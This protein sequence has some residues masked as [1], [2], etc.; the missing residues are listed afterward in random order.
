MDVGPLAN[1]HP[2]PGETVDLIAT[3]KNFGS[4]ATNVHIELEASDPYITIIDGSADLGDMAEGQVADNSA[5]PFSFEVAAHA[6]TG[7]I[8]QLSL[9]ATF[10]GGE[11]PSGLVVC[12]GRYDYLVWD[13][14]G[15]H[16]SGPIIAAILDGLHYS[17]AYTES[18]PVD[19]L[20]DYASLWVSCGVYPGNHVVDSGGLE[21]PAIVDYMANGGSVYL[22]GG[23]VWAY[24][25]QYGG[26]DFRPHFEIDAT[27]DGSGDLSHVLGE[28]GTFTEGMDLLYVGENSYID[29]LNPIG[30]GYA[31]MQNSSP[32]YSCG[33][34][35]DQGTYRTVGTSF[36]LGGLQDGAEPSTKTALV[37]EIIEFFEIAPNDTLFV[38]DFE[39]S[40]TGNWS[41]TVP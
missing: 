24:D 31:L 25:S 5:D 38:D 32:A 11:T 33:I 2:D 30:S 41:A 8:V 26:F 9:E 23:D 16:T 20:D 10:T 34:A 12:I 36:E 14:T 21:G 39:S 35:A 27:D 6:P 17:G 22:E 4:S 37:R 13:P 1:G 3:M 29:R 19:R 28:M 7:R 15:D 18:L 40:G